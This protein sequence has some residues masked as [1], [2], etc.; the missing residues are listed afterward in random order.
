MLPSS[1]TVRLSLRG[2]LL[3]GFGCFCLV[4]L[5]AL[6]ALWF[7]LRQTMQLQARAEGAGRL[8]TVCVTL[9]AEGLQMGQAIRNILLDPANGRA[10]ENRAKAW[11]SW[12]QAHAGLL[13]QMKAKPDADAPLAAFEHAART[14]ADR[15]SV[16]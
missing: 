10:Y 11:A 15:K 8:E 4:L 5:V 3:W 1:T 14:M 9:V 12:Q 6:G 16:V 7:S 13:A 2:L